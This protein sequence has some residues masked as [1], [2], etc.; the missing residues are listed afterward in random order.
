MPDRKLES[1]LRTDEPRPPKHSLPRYAD[2]TPETHRRISREEEAELAL[3][4]T[5]FTPLTK[6]ILIALFLATI[7]SVP[8]IQIYSEVQTKRAHSVYAIFKPLPGWRKIQSVRNAEGLWELLPQA[9]EIKAAERILEQ[10]SVL[11]Q[12]LLPGIQYALTAGLHAGSEQVYLGRDGWLFYRA[13]VDY[14]MGPPFLNA[15]RMTQRWHTAAAQPDAIK[16]IVDFRDQLAARGIELIVVP[17]PVKPT[18]EAQHLSARAPQNVAV[19]NPSFAEFKTRLT[20]AGVRIFDPVPSLMQRKHDVAGAPLYL[21]TDTHWR[22]ETMEFV[23]QKLAGFIEPKKSPRD[24]SVQIVTKEITTR[25]DVAAMLRFPPRKNI[26]PPEKV[27]LHEVTSGNSSWRPMGDADIL[28]LGDSF[29]NIFSLGAMGWGESAGFA[30]HLSFE[31]GGRPLDCIVRNSD[32]AFATREILQ[33]DLAR[34]RDRLAGKKLV[35]W[36]FAARELAFGNWK[37]LELKLGH[38]RPA[39]FFVPR[40]HE[41]VTVSG[42]VEAVSSAPRPGTVPYQDHIIAWHLVD[43]S[44]PGETVNTNREAIVY[45]WSMRDNQW[46]PAARVRAGDRVTLRL[47]PWS[48]VSAQYEKFNR[49]ELDDAALQMEEPTWG[50]IVP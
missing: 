36:E 38:P 47:R 1:T 4:N 14:V 21:Q 8:F 10:E 20:S 39:N 3:K 48:D 11:A 43:I 19:N 31:L 24:S 2:P 46:T 17:V 35:I 25:G 29:S 22:P 42:T 7:A 34:G 5:A 30:E 15:A 16:A 40:S 23:A 33:H 50:E 13:D 32:G 6:P 41:T 27:T 49:T 37:M 18:I 26:Y 45:L 12:W 44:L 28:F 9:K